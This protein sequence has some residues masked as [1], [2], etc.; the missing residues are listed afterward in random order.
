ML[1]VRAPYTGRPAFSYDVFGSPFL[2]RKVVSYFDDI[3]ES[4]H[5]V[6]IHPHYAMYV[7]GFNILV[8]KL[9]DE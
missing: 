8:E 7:R 5:V 9:S 2:V 1:T 3:F 6:K 4:F